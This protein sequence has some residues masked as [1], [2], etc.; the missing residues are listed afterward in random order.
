MEVI[1]EDSQ[2]RSDYRLLIQA[3]LYGWPG[4]I[5]DKAVETW[6]F[7]KN[8]KRL[9]AWSYRGVQSNPIDCY[10]SEGGCISQDLTLDIPGFNLTI[11]VGGGLDYP[12]TIY[13]PSPHLMPW[14]IFRPLQF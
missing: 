11:L 12:N 7:D 9:N 10:C 1:P 2:K 8:Y 4:S 14:S 6:T 5:A 3:R 13:I